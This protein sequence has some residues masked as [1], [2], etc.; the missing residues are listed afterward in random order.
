[1]S[2]ELAGTITGNIR[3]Y[4]AKADKTNDGKTAKVNV[5]IDLDETM[6]E[7][8]GGRNFKL[9]CFAGYVGGSAAR[10]FDSVKFGGELA[11]KAEHTLEVDGKPLVTKPRITK[12]KLSDKQ[13]LVT[14]TLQ[15]NVPGSSKGLRKYLDES[16]GDDVKIK[17]K[18]VT[19]PE[20]PETGD[21]KGKGKR[22]RKKAEEGAADNQVDAFADEDDAGDEG[23]E[24]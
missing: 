13:R 8:F 23:G 18:G 22:G 7:R 5:E 20:L 2:L 3:R 6:A 19:Q 1:M 15:L 21:G 16:A 12:C 24:E 11:I 9:A 14:V 10:V 17:V 4:E